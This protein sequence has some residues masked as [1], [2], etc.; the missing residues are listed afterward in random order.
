MKIYEGLTEFTPPKFPVVTSGTFDGVHKGHQKIIERI[1]TIAQN[2]NGETVLI[3]Y[4]PHP[5]FVLKPDDDSLK[6]LNTFEEKA[7]L[8]EKL[9]V[10]HLIKFTFDKKFSSQT[11]EE[12]IKNIL[13]DGINTKKLVIGYDHRFG[14]NREGSF[15]HLKENAS[16]YGFEVEEIPEQDVNNVAVSSTK[17]RRALDE[18]NVEIAREYLGQDYS[19]TGFVGEGEKRGR[20]LGFPTANITIPEKFKKIPAHG[21]YGVHADVGGK[22]YQGMMNI[23]VKPTFRG[24]ELSLE[25]HLFNFNENIYGEKITVFFDNY[26][27]KERKFK[28][29]E[30]LINQLQ[31]D[32]QVVL[33]R[34]NK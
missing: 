27:R 11:S 15:E 2:N 12:F 29:T 23:G 33:D 13:I 16:K 21:V 8:L 10:D 4:W 1:K 34:L 25:V 9:G 14:K 26:V 3:T 22:R 5:R 19:I 24:S 6:L 7:L 20:E 18:G 30:E 28:N 17:I 32:R 31:I